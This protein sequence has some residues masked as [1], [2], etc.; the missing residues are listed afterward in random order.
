MAYTMISVKR[1]NLN[2]RYMY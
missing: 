2:K 1:S